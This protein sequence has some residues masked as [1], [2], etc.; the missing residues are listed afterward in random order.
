MRIGMM[1]DIYKPHISGITNYIELNKRYLEKAGH[2]VFVFTFGDQDYQD[3]ERNIIRSPGLPLVDTGYYVSFQYSRKAKALLQTMD[4]AHVHHP[5][6]SGR[7]A[8][9]YC[10]PLNIPVIFTNHTRYDLYAQAYLPGLPSE[11]SQTLL[12]TYMPDFCSSVD[13]VVSPSAG[14]EQVLRTFKVDV[15]IK[16]IPNGV[17]LQRFFN[18]P[19]PAGRNKLGLAPEDI[20]LVYSGRLAPE[21]NL[22][23][24][25]E[26]FAGVAQAVEHTHLLLIGD[27]PEREKLEEQTALSGL[28]G[29]VHFTGRVSYDRLPGYLSMCDAFVTAS[30]S[31]VHPLSV[32]EA[33]ASG[34]PVVGIRSVGVGDTVRDGITGFLAGDDLAAFAAKLTR[35]CL[36]APLRQKMGQ[37]AHKECR[38]YAIEQ[39]SAVM[40]SHY[41]RLS[42]EGKAR[43]HGL[44]FRWRSFLEALHE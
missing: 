1:A 10:R 4:I 5:F 18:E 42:S 43:K 41:E 30:V 8:L 7:L 17:E 6:L 27:G 13:M 39:T 44:R 22:A 21:K 2:D 3:E 20:L 34:L 33:M 23:F 9:R 35:L 11:V 32:I 19:N 28:T 37:A 24:L 14:M 15:P 38:R 12:E 40:V 31:E 25:L 26:A 29:R 36:D 16:I